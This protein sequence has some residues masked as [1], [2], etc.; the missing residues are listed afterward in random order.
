MSPKRSVLPQQPAPNGTV[1]WFVRWLFI[2]DGATQTS[3]TQWFDLVLE[4][5]RDW[6]PVFREEEA[7]KEKHWVAQYDDY[8]GY[9]ADKGYQ[10]GCAVIAV[11][12]VAFVGLF[13]YCVTT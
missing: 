7:K 9:W 13:N 5:A 4:K 6:V 11:F 10:T 1:A 2:T 12:L 8:F 3:W